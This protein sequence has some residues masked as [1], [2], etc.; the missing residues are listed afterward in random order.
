MAFGAWKRTSKW[1]G[2]VVMASV[3]TS[4]KATPLTYFIDFGGGAQEPDVGLFTYDATTSTF[5][6]FLVSWGGKV[7]DLTSSANAPFVGSACPGL[8][9][10]GA[11]GFALMSKTLCDGLYD[12]WF[13]SDLFSI[14]SFSFSSQTL[15]LPEQNAARISASGPGSGTGIDSFSAGDWSLTFIGGGSGTPPPSS[16]P[17]PATLALL[18]LCLAGLGFARRRKLN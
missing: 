13:G 5:S 2:A 10:S 9:S 8:S 1:L 17:E 3:L 18:G 6:N 12:R 4:A 16:V 14:S 7:F 11:T 15:A